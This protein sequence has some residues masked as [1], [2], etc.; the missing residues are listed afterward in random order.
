[1]LDRMRKAA[2]RFKIDRVRQE[3]VVRAGGG[4]PDEE[5]D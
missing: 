4:A 2:G 5:Q 1:V 3:D